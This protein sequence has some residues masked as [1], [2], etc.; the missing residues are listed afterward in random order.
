M[1]PYEQGSR[2][3]EPDLDD[4]ARLMRLVVDEP[5]AAAAVG[6]QAERDIREL[7]NI[8]AAG[9][10]I[11]EVLEQGGAEWEAARAAKR[12]QRQEARRGA[13]QQP[14][15]SVSRRAVRKARRASAAL[16]DRIRR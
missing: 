13:Q 6:E 8:E 12:A 11:R 5:A 2:W 10:R 14:T 16:A 4:A 3:A 9:V 1:G 15:A 7:H